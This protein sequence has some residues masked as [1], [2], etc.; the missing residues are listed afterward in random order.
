MKT[1]KPLNLPTS[2]AKQIV[3]HWTGGQLHAIV[4]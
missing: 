2:S 1:D 3:C 4:P